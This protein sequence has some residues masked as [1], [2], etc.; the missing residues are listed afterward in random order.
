MN[1]GHATN[2]D[3]P[4]IEEI[5]DSLAA[6]NHTIHDNR[7]AIGVKARLTPNPV[8]TPFPPLKFIQTGKQWPTTPK[9]AASDSA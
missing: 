4:P 3:N 2:A 6:S 1:K 8:A 9:I 5:R 7:P